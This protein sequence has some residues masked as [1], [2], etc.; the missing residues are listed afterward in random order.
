[1]FYC[2]YMYTYIYVYRTLT[3]EKWCAVVT[4]LKSPRGLCRASVA[5]VTV[6]AK[7]RR[8]EVDSCLVIAPMSIIMSYGNHNLL[9]EYIHRWIRALCLP[10][11][12]K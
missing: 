1:M 2:V 4:K 12:Q 7:A 11:S 8:Q 6:E 5:D 9:Y 10:R 3:F